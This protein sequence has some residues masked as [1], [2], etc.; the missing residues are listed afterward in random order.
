MK[1][2]KGEGGLRAH[3]PCRGLAGNGRHPR[4]G[5]V[6]TGGEGQVLGPQSLS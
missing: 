4:S 6:Q 2:K 5:V 3:R 1:G